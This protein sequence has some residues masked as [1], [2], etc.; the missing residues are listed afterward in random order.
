M[1]GEKISSNN[2]WTT[3]LP[4]FLFINYQE[5]RAKGKHM[6]VYTDKL[7]PT[8]SFMSKT[9]SS[10]KDLFSW[11]ILQPF[12]SKGNILSEDFLPLT[13]LVKERKDL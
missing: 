7:N 6:E 9:T 10:H 1:Q 11:K 13:S 5:Q 12:W 8:S 4:L 2:K 3:P